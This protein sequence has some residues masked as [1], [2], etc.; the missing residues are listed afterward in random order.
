MENNNNGI[1]YKKIDEK[2]TK[3]NIFMYDPQNDIEIFSLLDRLNE[4]ERMIR[5][6]KIYKHRYFSIKFYRLV[7]DLTNQKI[8]QI[9]NLIKSKKQKDENQNLIIYIEK[10]NEKTNNKEKT[11]YNLLKEI[12]KLNSEDQ[13]L[14][15]FIHHDDN[16]I[17][18]NYI[19]YLNKLYIED[20]YTYKKIDIYS[21]TILK[22]KENTFKNEIFNEI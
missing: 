8:S 16:I 10:I 17:N 1:K 13:P 9:I 3:L 18:K 2:N 6:F 21:L 19:N 14:L 5:G 22:Y 12:S 7:N 15:L 11:Y 20:P 4:E